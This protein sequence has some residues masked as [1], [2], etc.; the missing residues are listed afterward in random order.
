[1][2]VSM[3]RDGTLIA[4]LGGS[5]YSPASS[6]ANANVSATPVF[7]D[8]PAAGD[9]TYSFTVTNGGGSTGEDAQPYQFSINAALL[10]TQR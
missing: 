4:S 10:E 5:G 2:S 7:I 6:A 8:F 1:V 9:H 3:S